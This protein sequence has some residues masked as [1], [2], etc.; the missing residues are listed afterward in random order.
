[1]TMSSIVPHKGASEEWVVRRVL[2]FV[3]ELGWR[4]L[5]WFSG[6]TRRTLLWTCGR[7]LLGKGNAESFPED[8]QKYSSES[9]GFIERA[10]QCVEGQIRVSKDALEARI[11]CE[12]ASPRDG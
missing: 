4:I 1:M 12:L 6:L 5:L 8:S 3:R 9:N 7:K 2:A 11:G 10:V